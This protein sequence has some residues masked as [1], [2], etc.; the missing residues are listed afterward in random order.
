MNNISFRKIIFYVLYGVNIV[1]CLL[2]CL[3]YWFSF[4]LVVERIISISWSGSVVALL[5]CW[6]WNRRC[7]IGE[8]QGKCIAVKKR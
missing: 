8:C 5:F 4:S 2:C 3:L 6:I 1:C 7:D